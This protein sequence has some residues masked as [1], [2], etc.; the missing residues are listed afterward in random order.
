MRLITSL[1][2]IIVCLITVAFALLNAELVSINYLLGERQLPLSLLVILVLLAGI[3]MGIVLSF[4]AILRSRLK[5][6]ALT[7]QVEDLRKEID[8]IRAMPVKEHHLWS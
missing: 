7:K 4:K 6:H 8:T 3:L 5:T 1:F 2:I